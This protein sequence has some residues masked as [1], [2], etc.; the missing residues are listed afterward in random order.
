[1]SSG[2]FFDLPQA[3]C[4]VYGLDPNKVTHMTLD[5]SAGDL[6]TLTVECINTDELD[7]DEIKTTLAKYRLEPVES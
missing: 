2:P 6:P 3:L 5:M 4:E 7:V 1:M